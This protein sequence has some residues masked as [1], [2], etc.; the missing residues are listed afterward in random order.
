MDYAKTCPE[1]CYR[2]NGG[3]HKF[4]TQSC[5]FTGHKK[6]S[7]LEDFTQGNYQFVYKN[8]AQIKEQV[9]K[10]Q[11]KNKEQELNTALNDLNDVLFSHCLWADTGVQWDL[12]FS[13]IAH[14]PDD[15]NCPICYYPPVAP[16]LTKCGHILCADCLLQLFNQSGTKIPLC[17]VC[18]E[19]I[20]YEDIVRCKCVYHPAKIEGQTIVFT[21]VYRYMSDNICFCKHGQLDTLRPASDILN[22][23]NRFS[24]ADTKFID[25]TLKSEIEQL[26]K[27]REIYME[28]D[29]PGKIAAID[30]VL[31]DVSKEK[32]IDDYVPF[33]VGKH[34]PE[35]KMVIFYQSNDGRLVFLSDFCK[36][37]LVDQ[38]GSLENAPDTIEAKVVSSFIEREREFAHLPQG[39]ECVCVYADFTNILS[40]EVIDRNRLEI[41]ANTPV[42]HKKKEPKRVI[43]KDDFQKFI[44]EEPEPEVKMSSEQDFPS[45]FPTKPMPTLPKKKT[46]DEEFPSLLPSVPFTSNMPKKVKVEAPQPPPQEPDFPS[47]DAISSKEPK[48]KRGKKP[49]Q[50]SSVWQSLYT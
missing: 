25:Q 48:K 12:L 7:I 29:C 2:F 33:N 39:S 13:A 3:T 42:V 8:C 18:N 36:R 38:F 5:R 45:L 41:K 20:S 44:A 30:K 4:G 37:L 23:F 16:R 40:Q 34:K 19:E 1:E 15:Y 31:A 47:F 27:Q 22:R 21:K 26:T 17:P 35:E 6:S 32:P 11:M 49:K 46:K 28:F 43:T 50:K 14:L 10:S 9:E 24:I